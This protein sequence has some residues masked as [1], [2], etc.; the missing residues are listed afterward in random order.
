[1]RVWLALIVTGCAAAPVPSSP[2]AAQSS[3][4]VS[5]FEMTV[6]D[7]ESERA[8]LTA[9]DMISGPVQEL[10]GP[11]FAELVSVPHGQA[12]ELTLH[13]GEQ[14]LMLRQFSTPPARA[15]DVLR[16]NDT[17]FEHVALVVRDMNEAYRRLAM[18]RM[19]PV[20]SAPQTLPASNPVAAGIRAFYFRDPE[21]HFMELIQFPK[22]KGDPRWQSDTN[23]IFLGID[24][25]A[26]ATRSTAQSLRFYRDALGL[27]VM[28]ESLNEGHE[29]ELLSGVAGA[30]VKI[31][32]LRGAQGPGIELLEYLSPGPGLPFPVSTAADTSHWEIVLEVPNLDESLRALRASGGDVPGRALGGR[33][34]GPDVARAALVRDPDGHS[35]RLFERASE[36]GLV[37]TP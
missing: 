34:L 36:K 35:V 15:V 10:S 22:G 11:S 3:A 17:G 30:R 14:A 7:I 23:R 24:H 5:A 1:M 8:F 29:Q 21:G 9:F 4:A 18:T 26:I 20:S 33:F 25:S 16:A 6:L 28:S 12:H 19:R 27:R 32:S 2:R 31:T 13:L 37:T